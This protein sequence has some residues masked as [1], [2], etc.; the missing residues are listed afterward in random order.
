[1]VAD[2]TDTRTEEAA[3]ERDIERT[4]DEMGETVQKLEDSLNPREI[5]RS[6][7]GD[8]NADLAKQAWEV[9]REN[10]IPVAMIAVGAVW[11]LAT[12]NA[13]AIR[14]LRDRFRSGRTSGSRASA[15]LRP[16]SAEPAPIGPPPSTDPTLDRMPEES[17]GS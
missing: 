6:V 17:F 1:M 5:A 4:Q 13:P 8:D 9:A 10:P 16:R 12:S 3:I 2:T 15:G 11:L 14:Q 7:M